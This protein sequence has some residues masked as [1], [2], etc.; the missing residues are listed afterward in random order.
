M[1]NLI[2]Q[3]TTSIQGCISIPL[4]M[5]LV[6]LC[7]PVIVSWLHKSIVVINLL[8]STHHEHLTQEH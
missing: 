8:L 3:E 7:L 4:L 1:F 5:D 6:Y 2:P